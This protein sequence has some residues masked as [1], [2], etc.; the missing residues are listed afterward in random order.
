MT[1]FGNKEYFDAYVRKNEQTPCENCGIRNRHRTSRLCRQC[2]NNYQR[3]G[4]PS[5]RVLKY[6][7]IREELIVMNK[8]VEMNPDHEGIKLGIEFLVNRLTKAKDNQVFTGSD[9]YRRIARN[10]DDQKIQEYARSLLIVLSAIWFAF[11]RGRTLIKDETHLNTMLGHHVCRFRPLPRGHWIPVKLRQNIGKDC[12][13]NVG[14]LFVNMSKAG[15]DI[16]KVRET[17]AG[18]MENTLNT[19]GPKDAIW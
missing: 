8:V 18:I 3:T 7:D 9:Y 1:S 16:E 12:R 11:H 4:H 6:A 15:D 5:G 17:Q 13:H 19:K 2:S 14:V 10:A